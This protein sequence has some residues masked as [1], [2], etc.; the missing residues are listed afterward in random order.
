MEGE[1]LS[2]KLERAEAYQTGLW[3]EKIGDR[4]EGRRQRKIKRQVKLL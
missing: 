2:P 3:V 1:G 4:Q